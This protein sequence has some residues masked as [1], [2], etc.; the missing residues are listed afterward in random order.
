MRALVAEKRE[1]AL[2]TLFV[3]F[4]LQGEQFDFGYVTDAGTAPLGR[5]I[6]ASAQPL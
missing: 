1:V 3:T 2:G 6:G 4:D 5:R